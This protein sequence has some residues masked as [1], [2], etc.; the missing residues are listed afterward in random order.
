MSDMLAH[1]RCILIVEEDRSI[2]E[3]VSTLLHE[4]GYKTDEAATLTEA[5]E[6]IDENS[7]DLVLTDLFTTNNQPPRLIDIQGLQQRCYPIPVGILT[8]WRASEYEVKRTGFAFLLEKPFD[9]DTLLQ[10]IADSLNAPFTAEQAQQAQVIRRALQALSAGDWETLRALCTPTLCYYPLTRSIFTAERAFI[11]M[12]AYLDY[13]RLVRR[14]LP[15]FRIDQVVIFQH[16]K[17]LI[18]RYRASWQGSDGAWQHIANSAIC[19]FRGER[20]SQIGV[21]QPQ[22]RMQ[23]LVEQA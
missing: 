10:R 13:A 1:G 12:D 20:I 2:R 8:A 5:L 14:R 23:A 6:Q 18:T 15:G 16:T 4:E 19:R 3:M 17:G 9:L 11:G 21:A 22:A 7:Y